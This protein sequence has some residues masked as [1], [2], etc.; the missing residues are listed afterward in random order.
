MMVLSLAEM[1][2]K[3]IIFYYYIMTHSAEIPSIRE[4]DYSALYQAMTSDNHEALKPRF[5][6]Q[7]CYYDQYGQYV[8][9]IIAS[10]ATSESIALSFA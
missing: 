8:D 2:R 5:S 4:I 9:Y 1:S 6:G 10:D 7:I 3:N